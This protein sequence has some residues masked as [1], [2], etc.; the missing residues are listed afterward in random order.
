MRHS[1]HCLLLTATPHKG[2]VENFRHLMRLIDPDIFSSIGIKETLRDKT[3]PFIIRRLKEHLK[4]FDGS[5]LFPKR[6]TKTITYHLSEQ[7]LKL[8][9]AVTQYVKEHFNRAINR[10]K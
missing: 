1:D 3:N 7:E 8:Y 9:E 4:Y 2:D 10:G 6:T 5:P